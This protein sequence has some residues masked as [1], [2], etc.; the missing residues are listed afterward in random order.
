M[1]TAT[2]EA[3][4]ILI[5]AKG[6]P[7][8]DGKYKYEYDVDGKKTRVWSFDDLATDDIPNAVSV[9]EYVSDDWGNWVERREHHR[10]RSSSRW[11]I[12]ISRRRLAYWP[13]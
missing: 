7:L 1:K 8:G 4:I 2:S 13:V 10:G 9:F 11:G 5:T 3:D 6:G 12:R